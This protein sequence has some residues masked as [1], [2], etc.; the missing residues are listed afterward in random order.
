MSGWAISHTCE[1]KAEKTLMTRSI[2]A[3]TSKPH[4]HAQGEH[5][6]NLF[7]EMGQEFQKHETCRLLFDERRHRDV[8]PFDADEVKNNGLGVL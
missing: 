1:I 6:H 2:Y 3:K 5:A 7:R 4:L 8:R